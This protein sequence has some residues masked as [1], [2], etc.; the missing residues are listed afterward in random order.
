MLK[1]Y[2]KEGVKLAKYFVDEYKL[3]DNILAIYTMGS[4]AEGR[5]NE[6]SDIDLNIFVNKADY[7][8]LLNLKMAIKKTEKNLVGRLIQT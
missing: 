5:V 4:F 8:D 1:K 3:Q 2:L 6:K 7:N